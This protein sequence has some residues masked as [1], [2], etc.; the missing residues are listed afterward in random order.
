MVVVVVYWATAQ[1][2]MGMRKR[3][4]ELAG[5]GDGLEFGKG[6]AGVVELRGLTA[7]E[8]GS[9]AASPAAVEAEQNTTSRAWERLVLHMRLA[10][11]ACSRDTDALAIAMQ[12]SPGRST[13]HI[14]DGQITFGRTRKASRRCVHTNLPSLQPGSL[15]RVVPRT[16]ALRTLL[17]I[18]PRPGLGLA[19]GAWRGPARSPFS[20]NPSPQPAGSADSTQ[21]YDPQVDGVEASLALTYQHRSRWHGAL[22]RI[23]SIDETVRHCAPRQTHSF[24]CIN[25]ARSLRPS[26]RAWRLSSVTNYWC[27]R[28][29]PLS[30]P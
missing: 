27:K 2:T 23:L 11:F 4:D 17:H 15:H 25:F 13:R 3:E 6:T 26:F 16:A 19:R 7:R 22:R 1:R 20:L 24:G 29:A 8:Y 18:E 28:S 5:S 21:R 10:A 30:L 9:S 12:P 14:A